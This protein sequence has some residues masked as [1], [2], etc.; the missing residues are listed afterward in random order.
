MRDSGM[1]SFRSAPAKSEQLYALADQHVHAANTQI[2]A[3]SVTI[4]DQ[5]TRATQ[6]EAAIKKQGG[7]KIADKSTFQTLSGLAGAEGGSGAECSICMS[8]LGS[9]FP[10]QVDEAKYGPNIGMLKCGHFMCKCCMN[11]L[12]SS[13]APGEQK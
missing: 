1:Y 3:S 9:T 4:A 7:G 12:F 11:Q 2:M 5:A 10:D 6:M 13:G 8:E